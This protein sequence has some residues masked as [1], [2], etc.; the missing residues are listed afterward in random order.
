MTDMR[1]R[2][3]Y[4]QQ[5]KTRVGWSNLNGLIVTEIVGISIHP[6]LPE[7]RFNNETNKDFY[8]TDKR[9]LAH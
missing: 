5:K 6:F 2:L 1:H 9:D 7:Q 4:C 8:S 3:I